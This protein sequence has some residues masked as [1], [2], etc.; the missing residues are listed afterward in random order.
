MSCVWFT[1]M[2]SC[3]RAVILRL[4]SMSLTALIISM[5]GESV[6]N[7]CS[8]SAAHESHKAMTNT[9]VTSGW[10]W[11]RCHRI[12]ERKSCSSTCHHIDAETENQRS[13][14]LKCLNFE[15]GMVSCFG[16]GMQC[17]PQLPAPLSLLMGQTPQATVDTI[18]EVNKLARKSA[19]WARTPLKVHV[20]HSPAVIRT[21]KL[22][23]PV[24]QTAL[25]KADSWSS[26]QAPSCCKAKNQTCL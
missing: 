12:R 26:L 5:S 17:L 21:Q 18:H 8:N 19:A 14:H 13:F 23:G 6:S 11:D 15:L 4:G 3:W 2:T 7:E 16:L 20:H 1:S 9:P 24:G 10:I 25:L 22:E